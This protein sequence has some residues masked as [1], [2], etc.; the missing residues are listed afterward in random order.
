MIRG[1]FS[2]SAKLFINE[3]EEGP[4][5]REGLQNNEIRGSI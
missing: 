2:N 3:M 4:Y 1:G 5:G